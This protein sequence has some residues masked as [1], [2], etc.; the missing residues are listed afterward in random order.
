[1]AQARAELGYVD[2][3]RGRY[4]RAE[5][6]LTDALDFAHGSASTM[7][8]ATTY[9]GSVASDRA[10]YGSAVDLLDQAT[11]LSRAAG[12]PRTE[13]YG[14][15][16][17]GRVSL[18]RGELGPAAEQLDASIAR[19]EHGHWLAFLPWPQA[20]R[21][22][23]H[24]AAGDPDGAADAPRAGLRPGLPARRPVLGGDVRPGPGA[25][26]RGDRRHRAGVHDPRRRAGALEAARRPVRLAGGP[27]P[28]RAVRRSAGGTDTRR[29]RRW[30]DT[31]RRIASRTGMRELTVRSLLHGAA[32]GDPGDGAAAAMLAADI[33]NPA[34]KL[35][36]AR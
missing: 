31:M 30:I 21:G 25:G 5:L 6:W 2:F 10:D 15:A 17:L 20:L 28:R 35:L 19:A 13:A 11:A 32:L 9:L 16:M 7:A 12:E 18:L 29:P 4:D 27:H 24:L 23:V 22:E 1:M 36:L 33:D 34:L 26:G 8:K 14:L 3:L